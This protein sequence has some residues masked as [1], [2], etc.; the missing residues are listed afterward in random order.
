MDLNLNR[1]YKLEP[2][3]GF[4]DT[5]LDSFYFV[6]PIN[7]IPTC[8]QIEKEFL[9]L[10]LIAFNHPQPLLRKEGSI[11][12]LKLFLRGSSSLWIAQVFTCVFFCR[13]A[14]EFI[15]DLPRGHDGAKIHEG[16][17]FV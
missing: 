9:L 6:L 5:T 3:K 14:N 13:P 15:R 12:Y 4:L 8:S 1:E 10:N 17:S 7:E 11:F 2:S 16:F